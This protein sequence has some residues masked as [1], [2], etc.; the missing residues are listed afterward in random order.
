[1]KTKQNIFTT[2]PNINE[3]SGFVCL[4]SFTSADADSTKIATQNSTM[5]IDRRWENAFDTRFYSTRS[6]VNHK[7]IVRNDESLLVHSKFITH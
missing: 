3:S 2:K 7:K 1:M 5:E 4:R 6:Y